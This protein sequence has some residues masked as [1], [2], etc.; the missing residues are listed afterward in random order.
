MLVWLF[1]IVINSYN[2]ERAVD[3]AVLKVPSRA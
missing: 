1:H 2:F 3:P